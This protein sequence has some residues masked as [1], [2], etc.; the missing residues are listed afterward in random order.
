MAAAS[1]RPRPERRRRTPP[2][3]AHLLLALASCL[4]VVVSVVA[5][6][7]LARWLDPGY[8][9]RTRGIHVSSRVYGW[10]GRPGAVAEMGAGHVSLNGW[11]YRGRNLA[12]SPRSGAKRAI[13]LG[14]SIAFGYGV[15][16][17]QAFPQLLD[18]RDN[19][20]EAA[21]LAVQGYG[22]AQELLVLQRDGLRLRPD[23]VVLALCLR[24]DLAD[25]VL[26]VALYNGVTPRPAFRLVGDDLVLDD[27]VPRSAAVRA[28]AWLSDYSHL[29]NRASALLASRPQPAP[30]S[31]R[32]RKQDALRDEDYAVRLVAALVTQ[33][34]RVCR[35]RDVDFIVATFPNGVNFV[36]ESA[37]QRRLHERLLAAGVRVVDFRDRFDALGLDV[38]DVTLDDTGHLS[39]RGHRVVAETLERE[40]A[41]EPGRPR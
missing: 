5:A 7:W 20:I 1:T 16:D 18:S 25:A 35:Q 23:V 41:A 22:P 21:N 19:G 31:W 24:N 32:R 13:V 29:Y 34:H 17:E 10:A 3:A 15:A 2:I 14:D 30:G 4:V 9:V 11:G 36:A 37:L 28:V 27:T 39:P 26:T 33:M 38:G 40:I 8:L 12:A 6:E